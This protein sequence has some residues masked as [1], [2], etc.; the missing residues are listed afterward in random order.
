M[1]T[2]GSS[3]AVPPARSDMIRSPCH[4]AAAPV[5]H[6]DPGQSRKADGFEVESREKYVKDVTQ[7]VMWAPEVRALSWW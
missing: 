2:V 7:F 4:L 3:P 6:G 5:H 1:Y